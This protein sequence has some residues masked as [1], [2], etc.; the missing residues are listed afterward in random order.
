MIAAPLSPIMIEG[1]W[2]LPLISLG[3]IDASIAQHN[4]MG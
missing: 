4:V 2:V 3:M 1:A